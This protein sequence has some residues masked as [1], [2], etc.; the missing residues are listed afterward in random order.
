M[1]SAT[2]P[3]V[4]ISP[5]LRNLLARPAAPLACDIESCMF[6]G[7]CATPQRNIPSVAK[8]KGLSFTWASRKNPVLSRG[9]LSII[10]NSFRL[11]AG[12]IG[13]AKTIKSVSKSRL[14]CKLVSNT[15]TLYFSGDLPMFVTFGIWSKSYRKNIASF[16]RLR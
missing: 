15:S 11:S 16:L 2:K 1:T 7:H 12:T 14:S 6:L 10:A 8:S 13:V 5:A 4:V 3:E 9:T